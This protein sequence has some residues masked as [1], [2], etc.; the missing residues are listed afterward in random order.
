M[1][2]ERRGV[3]RDST[4]PDLSVSPTIDWVCPVCRANA[5]VEVVMVKSERR[6]DPVRRITRIECTNPACLHYS[7]LEPIAAL[8]LRSGW[9]R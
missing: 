6:T 2:L 9:L 4:N 5:V 1:P 3:G 7:R 8:P